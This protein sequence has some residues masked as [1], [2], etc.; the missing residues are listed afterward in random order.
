MDHAEL[1]LKKINQPYQFVVH[2]FGCKV[3]T[4]DTGL[5]QKNMNQNG[6]ALETQNNENPIHILNT[7]AVTAE[8]TQQAVRLIRKIKSK[9]PLATVVVTGCAAQVD[10]GKF[11]DLAGA[12]LVIANSHKGMLP[13]ILDQY[14]KGELKQKTFKSNIFKKEDL[15]VGG[16]EEAQHTRSFLKI[17]DGCNSFCSFCIIPYARGKSRSISITQLIQKIKS[18]EKQNIQE[19]VLTGVHIGD[20]QDDSQAKN[21]VLED[22]VEQVLLKTQVPRIR[23]SSLEPIELT[24]RLVALYK[25]DR[26]CSHFHMS[27]QSADTNVLK[28]MKRNY[29]ENE[30]RMSLEKINQLVPNSFVGMDVIAGFP[31]ETDEEFE[32]TY[33]VLAETPWTRLHVFPYSERQGTRAATFTQL[34]QMKRKERAARLRELS[35]H[36]LQSE[37]LK[38][39]G[40]HKKA[41][42]LNKPN[43]RSVAL[44]RDYWNVSFDLSQINFEQIKNTEVDVIVR[45]VELLDQDVVLKVHYVK[46]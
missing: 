17:Q 43:S 6:F 19:V 27:I 15:E 11:E 23:L 1:N 16:G 8:A 21:L 38:Q 40:L 37:A 36:R 42:V 46:N 44:T 10:T 3:N 39:I 4:Y 33:K 29:S 13:Q 5:I 45:G 18:L 35:L 9:Q 28:E 34:H 26:L 12:S 22:L 14:F 32:N 41:L 20:Y 31:T 25:N 24:D 2:T 7:C 30:V